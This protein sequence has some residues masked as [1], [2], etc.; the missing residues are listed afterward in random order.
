MDKFKIAMQYAMPK[1]GIS[2]LVGKLASAEAGSV[3]TSLI[4]AFIKQY[5]I[6]RARHFTKILR[7]IKPLMSS[8]LAH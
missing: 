3:T 8:L 1:H 2:R 6:D 4:K 5:K 7:T